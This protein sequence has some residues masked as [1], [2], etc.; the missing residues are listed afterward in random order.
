MI[1]GKE[2]VWLH[3]PKCAGTKIEKIF[4]TYFSD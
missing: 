1:I 3:F 4:E 2:F